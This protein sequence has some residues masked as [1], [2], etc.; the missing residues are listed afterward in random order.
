MTV[1]L[2][3][4]PRNLIAT[5]YC[6]HVTL[7]SWNLSSWNIV[8]MKHCRH[9]TL[10]PWNI[11]AMKRRHET[12]S[13]WNI[14][15]MKHCRHWNTAAMKPAMKH[16]RHEALPPWNIAAMKHCSYETLQLWNIAAM[17]HCS[18]ETLQ[19]R[20]IAAM[21]LCS[22]KTLQLWNIGAGY[23]EAAL[24]GTGFLQ[25]HFVIRFSILKGHYRKWWHYTISKLQYGGLHWFA[26]KSHK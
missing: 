14:A 15:T 4:V 13:W 10:S 23:F 16:C 17:K 25:S 6:R 12:L 7:P 5:K 19:L 1:I 20:N 21:K 18:Y 3:V 22:Y 9:E 24:F 26:L 11:V 2:P 8:T